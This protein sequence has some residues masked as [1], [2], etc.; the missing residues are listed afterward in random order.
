MNRTGRL[1]S[2]LHLATSCG[3]ALAAVQ[4]LRHGPW[5]A[6]ALCAAASVVP[7][8]AV[9][10]E[11]VIEDLLRAGARR[12]GRVFRVTGDIVRA[13][14]DAACCERWWTSLGT[15][16]DAACPHGVPRSSAA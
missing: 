5:W 7:V 4:E 14:L 10:R 12:E 2:A 6:A 1:L 15:A 11:T 9:V 8:V 13:S 16:H 3:L